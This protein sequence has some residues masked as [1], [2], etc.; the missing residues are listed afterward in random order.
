MSE[1]EREEVHSPLEVVEHPIESAK[2][3]AAEAEHGDSARTPAIAITGVTLVIS[4]AVA[5]VLA[6]AIVVYVLA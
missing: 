2:S 3:L 4:V 6:I 5:I 1:Q